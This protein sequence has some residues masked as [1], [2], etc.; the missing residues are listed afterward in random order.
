MRPRSSTRARLDPDCAA[1]RYR[2]QQGVARQQGG[3]VEGLRERERE[4]D[5]RGI[6][7][8]SF[9]SPAFNGRRRCNR[10]ADPRNRKHMIAHRL[11]AA[12]GT[13]GLCR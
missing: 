12:Y 6:A 2:P 7:F 4:G 10:I 13:M 5:R 8:R 3:V 1:V 11:A 9:D